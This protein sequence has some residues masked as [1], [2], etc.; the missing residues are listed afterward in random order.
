M[1]TLA[2]LCTGS[3]GSEVNTRSGSTTHAS[4]GGLLDGELL[5][6]GGEE[7]LDV[8]GGLCGGL[9][10]E[11]VGFSGVCLG[12]GDRDCALV[13]LFGDEIGFVSCEGDDNVL[14]GL[15]LKLLHPGLRLV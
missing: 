3:F 2:S 7:F 9:E 1:A 11:Q 6:D 10:E 14:V 15:T 12:I 4:L 5:C 8:L 13:W